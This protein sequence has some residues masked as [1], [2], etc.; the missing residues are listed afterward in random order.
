[1]FSV[2]VLAAGAPGEVAFMADE[3]VESI[4]E[5]RPVQYTAKH[6]SLFLEKILHKTHQLNKGKNVSFFETLKRQIQDISVQCLGLCFWKNNGMCS[7]IT[8]GI[9]NV[10][11]FLALQ[12][13][14]QME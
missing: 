8:A 4:A 6:F 7:I 2:A 12:W 10:G 1:M 3:V 5:L 11:Q 9:Q 14:T 13:D